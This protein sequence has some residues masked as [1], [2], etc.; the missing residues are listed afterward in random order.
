MESFTTGICGLVTVEHFARVSP[1]IFVDDWTLKFQGSN[2]VLAKMGESRAKISLIR[3]SLGRVF[4]Y[5]SYF[6][7]ISH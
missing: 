5:P 6:V 7:I 4:I 3:P 1:V 2:G